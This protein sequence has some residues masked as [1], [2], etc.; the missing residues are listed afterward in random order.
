MQLE[1]FQGGRKEGHSVDRVHAL[2]QA[3][4]LHA[5]GVKKWGTD[6]ATFNAIMCAENFAQLQAVFAEYKKLAGHDMEEAIKKEF[7]GDVQ[8][9]LSAVGMNSKP[10]LETSF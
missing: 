6:E 3:Q 9:G 8:D 1:F 7:S 10:V 5:A 4:D 2:K